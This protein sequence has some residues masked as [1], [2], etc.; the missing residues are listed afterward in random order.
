MKVK[1]GVI[2]SLLFAYS[3][4]ADYKGF[5]EGLSEMVSDGRAIAAGIR[6]TIPKIVGETH[7]IPAKDVKKGRVVVVAEQVSELIEEL[8]AL[9]ANSATMSER[10]LHAAL[11]KVASRFRSLQKQLDQ[12]DFHAVEQYLIQ[13]DL[14]VPAKRPSSYTPDQGKD[15]IRPDLPEELRRRIEGRTQ[16]IGGAI[17]KETEDNRQMAVPR[18]RRR[19]RMYFK[20]A[21]VLVAE[22]NPKLL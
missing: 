10:E 16:L 4:I 15:A 22:E 11:D 8:E 19:R 14:L 1:A 18:R 17:Q 20:R 2:G 21:P 3:F 13:G 12:K 6:E 9:K 7:P 5:K